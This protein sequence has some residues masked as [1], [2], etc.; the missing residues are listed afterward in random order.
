MVPVDHGALSCFDVSLPPEERSRQVYFH[1]ISKS[2]GCSAVA[3]L[4]RM[5][6]R[7]NIYTREGCYNDMLGANYS[8]TFTILRRPRDHVLSM[9]EYCKYGDN[10]SMSMILDYFNHGEQSPLEATFQEP[11]LT[12]RSRRARGIERQEWVQRWHSEPSFGNGGMSKDPSHCYCPY[13]MQT[14]RM[15]CSMTNYCYPDPDLHLASEHLDSLSAVGVAE[16]YQEN[17][18]L[19]L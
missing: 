5:V 11:L 10:R 6:G 19:S 16:A 3:D 9:Y 17:G 15:I 12:V 8:N 14:S 18:E 1:H 4:S 2:A 7:E 13:N